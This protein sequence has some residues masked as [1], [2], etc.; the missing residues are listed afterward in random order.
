MKPRLRKYM[1]LW[2]CALSQ[3]INPTAARARGI[4]YTPEA[5]YDDWWLEYSKISFLYPRGGESA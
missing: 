2:Y 3:I 4:G 5:A 1:G